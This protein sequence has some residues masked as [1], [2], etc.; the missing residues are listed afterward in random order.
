MTSS[1]E[2]AAPRAPFRLEIP[3]PKVLT[4]K[5]ELAL[6]RAAVER[7]PESREIRYSLA[8]KL[9]KA[10]FFDELIALCASEDEFRFLDLRV[11]ALLS[12]ESAEDDL[13]AR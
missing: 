5:E 6:Y 2:I 12:R 4:E 3:A 7:S 11:D 8:V 10:N 1:L 9:L 13:A